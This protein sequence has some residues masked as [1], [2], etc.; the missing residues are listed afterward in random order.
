MIPCDIVISSELVDSSGI[1]VSL[2]KSISGAQNSVI[3]DYT[4]IAYDEQGCEP[5]E[6]KYYSLE[7]SLA[8]KMY[9]FFESYNNLLINETTCNKY[10]CN[11]VI[12]SATEYW[13]VYDMSSAHMAHYE[14]M[15]ELFKRYGGK[16]D[17]V[18]SVDEDGTEYRTCQIGGMDK[19]LVE[20]VFKTFIIPQEYQYAWKT[21]KLYLIEAMTWYQWFKERFPIYSGFTSDDSCYD[22]SVCGEKIE[23]DCVDCVEYFYRG[24]HK[25]YDL[26][27][28]FVE[29]IESIQCASA[30]TSLVLQVNIQNNIDDIGEYS[31]ISDN[32]EGGVEYKSPDSYCSGTIY[33]GMCDDGQ[34]ITG[35]TT[36][37][38]DDATWVRKCDSERSYQWDSI[39]KKFLF[40]PN[41]WMEYTI[42]HKND[43]ELSDKMSYAEF[44]YNAEDILFLFQNDGDAST[45]SAATE[46]AMYADVT[47]SE[48]G[49]IYLN[50]MI[51]P[52]QEFLYIEYPKN[53]RNYLPITY[54]GKR[55][56]TYYK[57]RRYVGEV[58]DDKIYFNLTKIPCVNPIGEKIEA[59][60]DKFIEYIQN[61]LLVDDDDFV[62][63]KGYKYPI[64]KSY[65][66]FQHNTY[67][68]YNDRIIN[69]IP[70]VDGD[71]IYDRTFGERIEN[72]SD[73]N[74][75]TRGYYY[76]A[77]ND[78]ILIFSPYEVYKLGIISGRTSS[79]LSLLER[80]TNACDDIGNEL[81]GYFEV[82]SASTH[83]QPEAHSTLDIPYKIGWTSRLSPIYDSNEEIIAYWGD[84]LKDIQ[85][86][87][88]TNKGNVMTSMISARDYDNDNLQAIQAVIE[89]RGGFFPSDRIMA[90]FTYYVG[91]ILYFD[92]ESYEYSLFSEHYNINAESLNGVM[93]TDVCRLVKTPTKYYIH[94]E[95]AYDIFYYN[96]T[97]DTEEVHYNDET[98]SLPMSTFKVVINTSKD[99]EWTSGDTFISYSRFNG[100]DLSPVF[101]EEYKFGSSSLEKIEDNIYIERQIV[102][103]HEHNLQLLDIHTMDALEKY[104]NGKINI[105]NN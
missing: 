44:A 21:S 82:T 68:L 37:I 46:M 3:S 58:E 54:D 43:K 16:I 97:F 93:Y 52:I 4:K 35:G 6:F 77:L 101:R 24:G 74:N 51:V 8:N 67:Y 60:T 28:A 40:N 100:L 53:S 39:C 2:L 15:D 89:E 92:E 79:R 48:L 45:S 69:P 99:P 102:K 63:I 78:T 34:T 87:I 9:H 31:L 14:E 17:V 33:S 75:T 95:L 56:I 64:F 84:Y 47:T 5:I 88:V 10:V 41:A 20:T 71:I 66:V 55:Y 91:A 18:T 103:P 7:Y 104:G 12:S 25:M 62:T 81:L 49:F 32:W 94:Q 65:F 59:K 90:K 27:K 73:T 13:R 86:Y 85:Y 83:A 76:D 50:G 26:L 38:Y 96:I 11:N 42:A 80:K 22:K 36:A 19:Y 30:S 72:I 105:L 23:I 57:G 1:D 61:Y 70:N 29:G 98:V